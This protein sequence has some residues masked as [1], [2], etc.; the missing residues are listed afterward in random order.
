VLLLLTAPTARALTD[1][2]LLDQVQHTAFNYFWE[3]S[4]IFTGLIKDRSTSGSPCSIASQGFGISAICIGID[5]GWIT[6]EEGRARILTALNTY[7]T[8]PQGSGASGYIGYKGLYYH[9]LDMNT[10]VRTWDCEVS[11]IDSALLFAGIL[12]A[13]QYFS[14][15]DPGDVQVRALAD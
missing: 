11:T 3:Q 10:G 8:K 5:H 13:K 7:W 1:E 2:E 6:R 14:T 12:D 4:N 9:F 15:S